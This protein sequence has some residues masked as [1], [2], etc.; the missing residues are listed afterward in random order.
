MNLRSRDNRNQGCG[1][2]D[3]RWPRVTGLMRGNPVRVLFAARR[4][5]SSFPLSLYRRAPNQH[6]MEHCP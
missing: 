5:H 6:L 4:S 2:V 1:L 3:E